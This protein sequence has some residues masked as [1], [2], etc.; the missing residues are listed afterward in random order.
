M[1]TYSCVHWLLT[2]RRVIDDLP[3]QNAFS[4]QYGRRGSTEPQCENIPHPPSPH[5]VMDMRFS[6]SI[7]A[8]TDVH[9]AGRKTVLEGQ[10]ALLQ[11][12]PLEIVS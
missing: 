4:G 5:I 6:S 12:A 7:I 10:N 2:N 8:R 11:G 3:V 9:G 1:S